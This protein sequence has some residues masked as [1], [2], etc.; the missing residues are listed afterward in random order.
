MPLMEFPIFTEFG[1][2][3]R[4]TKYHI[5]HPLIFLEMKTE[6]KNVNQNLFTSA[7]YSFWQ[8]LGLWAE[9]YADIS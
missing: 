1:A 3:F 7:L 8:K 2:L 5:G 9:K 4:I 6:L